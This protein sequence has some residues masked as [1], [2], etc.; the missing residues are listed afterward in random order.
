MPPLTSPHADSITRKLNERGGARFFA[1]VALV[2]LDEVHLL[3][4]QGRGSALEAG[5]VSRI[6]MI[7]R[8]PDMAQVS[9][10]SS[11]H[12]TCTT[13]ALFLRSSLF[14]LPHTSLPPSRTSSPAYSSRLRC[15]SPMS[16]L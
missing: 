2:M 8:L 12:N 9:V 1:E 10:Q 15:P 5:V 3:G 11:T 13:H 14:Q 16:A 4:E 6:K 7:S